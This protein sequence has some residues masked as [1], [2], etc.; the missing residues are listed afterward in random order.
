MTALAKILSSGV[1]VGINLALFVALASLFIFRGAVFAAP[2]DGPAVA[3]IALTVA[4]IVLAAVGVGGALLAIW[5]YTALRE[6]AERT[7]E[8]AADRAADRKV[9]QLLREWGLSSAE[10]SGGG[11]EAAQAYGQEK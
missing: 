9:Q 7:A 11:E 5:G 4:T 6:H 2:W 1:L 8:G 10:D 3:T